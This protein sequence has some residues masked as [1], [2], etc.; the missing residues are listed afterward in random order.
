MSLIELNKYEFFKDRIVEEGFRKAFKGNWGATEH[1]K[2][3]GIVQDLNRLSYNSY[4]SHLR[5]INL[6]MDSSAKVVAPRLLHGSQWGIIDPLDTPDG[7][8]IGFHKH[9]SITT[10]ITKNC[11]IKECVSS[12]R[13]E[14]AY[15]SGSKA[16]GT[17]GKTSL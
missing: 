17:C 13:G 9:M 12:R 10:H 14:A 2:R 5:K 11:S 15:L 8:N 7:G 3:L 1:T 16:K 6:P 4:I